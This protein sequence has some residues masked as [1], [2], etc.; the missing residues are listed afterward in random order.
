MTYQARKPQDIRVILQDIGD[1]LTRMPWPP[2]PEG[3][4][5]SSIDPIAGSAIDVYAYGMHHA[6][7]CTHDSEVYQKVG[8]HVA[9]MREASGLQMHEGTKRFIAQGRDP[10]SI[11][12]DGAHAAGK[13]F[14]LRMRMNDLHDQVGRKLGI[15]RRAKG[16]KTG[17]MEP[18]YYTPQWKKEHPEWLIGDPQDAPTEMS[19]A[20]F[21][22]GAPN[23]LHAPVREMMFALACEAVTKYDIDGFEIDFC[24]FPYFLPRKMAWAHRHVMTA[25]VRKLRRMIAERAAERGRPII[26]SARVPDAV[27][28]ALRMGLDLEAWFSEKLLDMSVI[29]GGYTPFTTPWDDIARLGEAQG[30]SVLACLSNSMLKDWQW[31]RTEQGLQ[32]EPSVEQKL[33]HIRA[34]A[35]RAYSKGVSGF[36]LWNYFYEMSHHYSP[37][38]KEG[39][40]YLGYGFTHE[41]ADRDSLTRKRKAYLLD[42]GSRLG[43]IFDHMSWSG[44]RPLVITPATDGI[45]QTATFDVAD[46]LSAAPAARAQLWINI[47]DLFPEDRIDFEWNGLPLTPR[48]EDY[49]G[50]T[51]YANREFRFDIAADR[52]RCGVNEFTILLRDRTPRLEPFVTLDFARLTI[53]PNA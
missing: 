36:E 19:F 23:Y 13:D 30:I 48:D 42:T 37:E 52:I 20:A 14:W 29:S 18:Y 38:Q 44:Q 27:A 21:E 3:L 26:F 16:P 5:S 22:A 4:L 8:D 33:E 9:I 1:P 50:Q 32:P 15:E 31:N 45:G 41:L 49:R 11:M 47:V 10:V 39:V 24:R 7:G 46:D 12:C 34:A 2:T 28:L 43:D 17:W 53:D 6:G 35:Y 51:L 40:H 25:F